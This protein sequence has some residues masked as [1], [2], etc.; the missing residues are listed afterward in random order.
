MF[1]EAADLDTLE[2]GCR[3]AT[4]ATRFDSVALGGSEIY[5]NFEGV[6]DYYE[7]YVDG[8][9]AGKGGDIEKRLTAFEERK[10]HPLTRLVK[11]GETVH[12]AVRVYDWYGAGGIFRPVTLSTAAFG[13]GGDLLR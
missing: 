11:P 1:E 5:L 6:D 8:K 3:R 4:Y 13:P 2:Q 7:L 9:S 10:S 12:L